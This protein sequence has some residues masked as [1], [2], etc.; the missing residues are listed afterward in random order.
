MN[1]SPYLDLPCRTLARAIADQAATHTGAA[2]SR[3]FDLCAE[4]PNSRALFLEVTAILRSRFA[5]YRS[6]LGKGI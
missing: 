1:N 3:A 5:T 2:L 6:K 4:F